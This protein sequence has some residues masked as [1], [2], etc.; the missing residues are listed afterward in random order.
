M[1]KRWI[2]GSISLL[3]VILLSIFSASSPVDEA[4]HRKFEKN[5]RILVT[6]KQSIGE[7]EM[8]ERIRK[9]ARKMDIDCTVLTLSRISKF[10]KI[11]RRLTHFFVDAFD[12][13]FVISLEGGRHSFTNAIKYVAMTHGSDYYFSEHPKLPFHTISDCYDGFLVSFPDKGTLKTS[14]TYEQDKCRYIRWFT[15]CPSTSYIPTKNFELFYCGTN[16]A[17]TSYGARFKVLFS[18]LDK[19]DYFNVYGHPLQWQHAPRSYRGHIRHDGESIINT[20]HKCGISLVLH[21]PDHFIGE[22][23]TAKIFESAAAGCVIICDKLPFIVE[24]FGDSVLYI[25]HKDGAEMF[26]QID[27]HVRWIRENPDLA[28]EKAKKSHEIFIEKFTLE[29]QLKSLIHLHEEITEEKEEPLFQ[30]AL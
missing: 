4:S 14:F 1:K 21:G 15:T 26:K 7:R 2:F 3:F 29:E 23:P 13:D 5:Y 8:A 20:M 27:K 17:N 11:A 25:D 6:H 16:M 24:N 9:T 19:T 28:R 22:T 10:R 30:E 18:L 12:P